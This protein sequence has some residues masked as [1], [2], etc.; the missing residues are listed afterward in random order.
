VRITVDD[1]QTWPAEV[2]AACEE[3]AAR[4]MD[5]P[6]YVSDLNLSSENEDSFRT[7]LRGHLVVAF[8]ATRL[9]PHEVQGIRTG[10]LRRLTAELVMDRVE[11]ASNHG[12]ITDEERAALRGAHVFAT[13]EARNREGRVC[14]FLSESTLRNRLHGVRPLMREWGGEAISMSSGGAGFRPRLRQLGAPAIV[15]ATLNLDQG[16]RVHSVWPG[17][18]DV[19]VGRW[20]GLDDVDA[21]VHFRDDVPAQHIEAVWLPGHAEY[22][23]FPGLPRE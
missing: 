17:V 2:Q 12:L 6:E 3:L 5:S 13:G 21:D 4:A 18:Q 8:H 1:P 22:D 19:F 15:V 11:Q 10:G 9:L 7:L 20:L 14:F 23:R 16:Q